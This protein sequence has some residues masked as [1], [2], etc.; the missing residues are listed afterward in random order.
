M[1]TKQDL[2]EIMTLWGLKFERSAFNLKVSGSPERTSFRTVVR[3][4][5]K[6]YLVEQVPKKIKSR[7]EE[8]INNLE[9]L[10]KKG[11]INN[12]KKYLKPLDGSIL[13]QYQGLYWQVSPFVPGVSLDRSSYI[14]DSWR[15]I[16]AA[17]FLINMKNISA[18]IESGGSF[19]LLDYVNDLMNVIKEHSPGIH[20]ELLPVFHYLKGD[21]FSSLED[22]PLA[23]CHGDFHPINIIWS[24]NSIASVIDWE[25]SGYRCEMYDVALM[26]GCLGIEDPSAFYSGFAKDFVKQLRAANIFDERSWSYLIDLILMQRFAWMSEWLRKSDKEMQV[27]ELTYIHLIFDNYDVIRGMLFGINQ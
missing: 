19:S 14:K 27:L 22:L 2:T 17:N 26:I 15:G 13:A 24:H 5:G 16:A 1:Y 3:A 18:E 20:E 7:K 8:I 4:D 21:F 23:F 6:L 10:H 9:I 12:I 25:F 11:N